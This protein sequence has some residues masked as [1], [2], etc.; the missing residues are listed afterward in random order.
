MG[1][2]KYLNTNDPIAEIERV[3][4]DNYEKLYACAYRMVGNHQDTEDVLQEAFIKAYK[5]ID[6]FRGESKLYTWIYRI[7]INESYRCFERINK[8]PVTCI[9]ERLG[10]DEKDFFTSIDYTPNYDDNLIIDEMREKCLQGFLKCMPKQQRVCFLLKTCLNLKNE[11][12]AEVLDISIENV[13]V[14]LHRGRKK[15]QELFALRCNL[16]DPDKPC[17]CYLWIKF[18]KDH[19]LEIPTVHYQAKTEELKKEHFKNLSLLR[20]IDY[21]YT[22]EAKYTK[23]VFINRLKKAIEIM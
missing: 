17:K 8:L 14:T 22:V 11:E 4:N 15:L 19:N 12:I 23:D 2:P 5:K 1:M 7:V 10:I 9:T 20:K 18:M 16:I 6:S 13:K 21:L 3:Y